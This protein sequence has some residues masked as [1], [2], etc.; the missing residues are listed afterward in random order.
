MLRNPI[1][2]FVMLAL[3]A[4]LGG[5]W[6]LFRAN[7]SGRYAAARHVAE[8][9]S[10][11]RLSLVVRHKSGAIAEEE[12]RMAD[13]N[14]VSS[15][16]YRAVGRNGEAIKVDSLPRETYD[17]SFF[18]E[19]TVSDGIWQLSSRPPRGDTSTSYAID[20]YQ[21]TGGQHGSRSITFTDPHYWA[22]TGGH[23]FHIVLDK[24]KPVPN[25]LQL[26]STVPVEPRYQKLVDDFRSFG[27][28]EFRSKVAAI[29]ARLGGRS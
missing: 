9:P 29:V 21:L 6:W 7:E 16:Q 15:S 12:Y 8:L 1:A 13:I 4:G 18:F 14:G 23:Q 10:A 17:V 24:N 19:K 5:M 27:S 22:T 2:L 25:L 26:S 11:I 28:D 20:V 3:F